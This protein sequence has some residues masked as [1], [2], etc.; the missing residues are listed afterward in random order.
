MREHFLGL[1]EQMLDAVDPDPKR[2]LAALGRA[3]RGRPCAAATRST[4]AASWRWWPPTE[5]R[6]VLDQISGLMSL[7]E[8][9]GDVTMDRAGEG[10][11]PS[12]ERFGRV[13]R[14]RRQSAQGSRQAAAAADRARGQADP[15]RAGRAVHR[16]GRVGRRRRLLDQAWERPANLP[17]IAEIRDPSA[18]IV[19]ASL[20]AARRLSR[21]APVVSGSSRDRRAARPGAPSRRRGTAGHAARCPAGPTRWPCWCWPSAHGCEV[22][23]VH[24]DHGLRAG[25]RPRPSRCATPPT[26]SAPRSGPSGCTVEPGPNLEARARAARYARAAAPMPA[27][28]HRRRPGR[29][30]PAEPPARGGARRARPACAR[31]RRP[32][33]RAAAR[34][35]ARAVRRPR[36]RVR[37]RPVNHDPALP[38]QPGPPRAAAA[39]RRHRRARRRARAGPPG[40]AGAGTPPTSSTSGAGTSTPPTPRP[41]AAPAAVGPR[42][43]PA[44]WLRACSSRAAPPR[45]R[46]RRAGARGGR[47]AR[48]W[49]PR[50]AADGGSHGTSGRLAPRAAV[51]HARLGLAARLRRSVATA[52]MIGL[53]STIRTIP[54]PT[55]TSAR[56]S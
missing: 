15:V 19:A 6:A 27:R 53:T 47:R 1:V 46:D 24:V 51:G 2:F 56:S 3:G 52:R 11:I 23:A 45:R 34:R 8:G 48:R 44:A 5:Q 50:S 30:R 13:L 28:P 33:P 38:A 55:L 10:L 35:D 7:L 42:R 22:T 18:W 25:R 49:P 43:G 14:Q 29:D 32:A 36:P 39:A 21:R 26:A 12:A 40:R 31:D 54:V 4:T 20:P 16:R 41:C 37:R 9:H 17:S